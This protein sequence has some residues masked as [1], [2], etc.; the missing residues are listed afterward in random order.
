MYSYMQMSSFSLKIVIWS[1]YLKKKSSVPL[2]C[3]KSNHSNLIIKL[4]SCLP[5]HFYYEK[6]YLIE[7]LVLYFFTTWCSINF[8]FL[9]KAD[10]FSKT[11][12]IPKCKFKHLFTLKSFFQLSPTVL[13]TWLILGSTISAMKHTGENASLW[14]NDTRFCR[15]PCSHT[16]SATRS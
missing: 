9:V 16:D 15:P 2:F 4:H 12:S 3:R 1:Y 10:H 8:G 13:P 5:F 7:L 6:G 11:I 14:N